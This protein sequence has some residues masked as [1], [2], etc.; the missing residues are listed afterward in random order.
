MF[1]QTLRINGRKKRNWF[2]WWLHE[3][4]RSQSGIK[5]QEKHRNSQYFSQ[6]NEKKI[7]CN[8]YC[9]KV[10]LKVYKIETW[11]TF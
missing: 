8:S 7:I 4:H 6:M 5:K 2:Y 9:A 3:Q 10:K 11:N 1:L